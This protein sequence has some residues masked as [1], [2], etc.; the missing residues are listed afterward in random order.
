MKKNLSFVFGLWFMLSV[1]SNASAATFCQNLCNS[2]E[3]S[4]AAISAC[5]Q[6]CDSIWN[7]IFNLS[8]K[9]SDTTSKKIG[10]S[11]AQIS[12][13]KCLKSSCG[14]KP[15]ESCIKRTIPKCGNPMALK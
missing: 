1:Q 2:Q 11:Q 10:A 15:S 14:S 5:I 3:A 8:T 12:S 13:F 4:A 7:S 6:G 9:S